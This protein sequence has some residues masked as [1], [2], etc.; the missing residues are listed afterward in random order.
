MQF[1]THSVW[2]S[3]PAEPDWGSEQLIVTDCSAPL[4]AL[5]EVIQRSSSSLNDGNVKWDDSNGVMDK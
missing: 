1:T 4:T 2:A 5:G 3:P